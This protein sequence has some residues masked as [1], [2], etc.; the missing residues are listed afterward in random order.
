MISHQSTDMIRA[1]EHVR[2]VPEA[3]ITDETIT[4]K[5]TYE[6]AQVFL[7][8]SPC[9][10]RSVCLWGLDAHLPLTNH[11]VPEYSPE[12]AELYFQRCRVGGIWRSDG[13]SG[14]REISDATNNKSSK[15]AYMQTKPTL[16]SSSWKAGNTAVKKGLWSLAWIQNMINLKRKRR[17][18]G[19]KKSL[20]GSPI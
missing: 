14:I 19:G 12:N 9:V 7:V 13:S 16:S 15:P 11:T 4:K 6:T 8:R 20:I 17:R 2:W 3:R 1:Y 18:R 5:I 10:S